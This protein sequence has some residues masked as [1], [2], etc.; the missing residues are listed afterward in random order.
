VTYGSDRPWQLGSIVARPAGPGSGL[1]QVRRLTHTD[2][3]AGF[4]R[5]LY[6]TGQ[7]IADR[8]QVHRVFQ[9][10]RER[11]HHLVRVIPGPF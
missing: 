1:P 3:W 11:G 6:D 4:Q 5:L 7:V 2:R 9:P 8:I 10:D